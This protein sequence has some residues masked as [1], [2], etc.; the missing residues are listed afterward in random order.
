MEMKWLLATA[1]LFVCLML[2]LLPSGMA[3]PLGDGRLPGVT[4]AMLK[5]DFWLAKLPAPRQLILD[6][7]GIVSFNQAIVQALPRAVVDLDAFPAAISRAGL[8]Q[9]LAADRL[10]RGQERYSDGTLL[11]A[12][13]YD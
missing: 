3:A 1:G 7:A 2:L 8:R 12:G 9:W 4:D 6:P 13:F 10:P 5:A 11:T